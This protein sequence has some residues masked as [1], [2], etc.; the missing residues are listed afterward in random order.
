MKKYALRAFSFF[1]LLVASTFAFTPDVNA[2]GSGGS[3]TNMWSLEIVLCY[4]VDGVKLVKQC[5]AAGGGC[6][7]QVCPCI[8]GPASQ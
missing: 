4:T 3:G 2:M 6:F 5:D 1:L 8:F 7:D